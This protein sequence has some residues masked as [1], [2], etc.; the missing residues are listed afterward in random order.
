MCICVYVYMYII[1]L[2]KNAKQEYY[3]N[4]NTHHKNMNSDLNKYT[5]AV[6]I[7]IMV[8][9]KWRSIYLYTIMIRA[10]SQL[11]LQLETQINHKSIQTPS[12]VYPSFNLFCDNTLDGFL[13]NV[14]IS[15]DSQM[16]GSPEN[17][18][19]RIRSNKYLHVI[20]VHY[21]RG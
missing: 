15:F 12:K 16:H 9:M 2:T 19:L 20:A 6:L 21:I 8:V 10:N 11:G 1:H 17:L 4:N 5:Q 13:N 7:H 14:S 18:E 3:K